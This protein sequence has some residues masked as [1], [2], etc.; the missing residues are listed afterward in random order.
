MDALDVVLVICWALLAVLFVRGALLDLEQ[1]TEDDAER[2]GALAE[3][4]QWLAV[5]APA[6]VV[7]SERQ[8][9]DPGKAM[10]EA[11]KTASKADRENFMAW[12]HG[13][14]SDLPAGSYR[15]VMATA[16][17]LRRL[18]GGH[19]S[20]INDVRLTLEDVLERNPQ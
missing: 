11:W 3:V 20:L 19:P 17:K 13:R 4:K 15:F 14:G 8:P 18:L 10:R 5:N 12:A 16:Q 7:H 1:I 6:A 2:K 9:T